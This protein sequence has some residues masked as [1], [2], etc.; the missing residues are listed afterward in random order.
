VLRTGD[1]ATGARDAR[2]ARRGALITAE[3][4][5]FRYDPTQARVLPAGDAATGTVLE[6]HDLPSRGVLIAA[7]NGLFRYDPAQARVLPAGDPHAAHHVYGL[8]DGGVLIGTSFETF[9]AHAPTVGGT[10]EACNEFVRTA[11]SPRIANTPIVPEPL[12]APVSDRL[13]LTLAASPRAGAIQVEVPVAFS[14]GAAP[15][16][17]KRSCPLPSRSSPPATGP[18]NCAKGRPR[19]GNPLPISVAGR[20]F[21][22]RLASAWP[23]T[24]AVSAPSTS[25]PSSCSCRQHDT[26]RAVSPS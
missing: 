22:Q 10:G 19:S 21:G 8:P 6:M 14:N 15:R 20:S 4:G 25:P 1:A 16:K 12:R 9:R 24:V 7:E 18:C 5:L 26:A 17:T 2:S 13:G 3:N 11:T 23:I